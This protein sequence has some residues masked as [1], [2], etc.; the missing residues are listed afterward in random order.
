MMTAFRSL[1]RWIM[2]ENTNVDARIDCM[3][4]E[5]DRLASEN[6]WLRYIA[7]RHLGMGF[8][9]PEGCSGCDEIKKSDNTI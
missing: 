6:K 4:K 1:V 7:T 9:Q 2:S 8:D 3:K 5:L